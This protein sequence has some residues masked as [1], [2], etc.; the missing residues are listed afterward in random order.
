MQYPS[1]PQETKPREQIPFMLGVYV[2]GH[3]SIKP[4]YA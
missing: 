1:I 3:I 2:Y 4:I